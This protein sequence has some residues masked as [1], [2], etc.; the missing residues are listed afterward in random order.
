MK[1]LNPATGVPFR[2]GDQREDGK[3]FLYYAK[4]QPCRPDDCYAETWVSREA[5]QRLRLVANSRDNGPQRTLPRL[6]NQLLASAKK[7]ARLRGGVVTITAEWI[8]RKLRLGLCE[9]TGL[10]LVTNRMRCNKSPSLDRIDSAN[11]D[12][13][14]ENTRLVCVQVNTAQGPW[15]DEE[16]LPVL[17]ELVRAMEADLGYDV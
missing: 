12:Y 4:T 2:R 9:R 1:R 13:T 7:R 11:R 10:R 8:L 15:S 14:P 5:E 6:A 3:V 17:R 16:S